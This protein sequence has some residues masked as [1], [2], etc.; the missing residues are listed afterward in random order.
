VIVDKKSN[1]KLCLGLTNDEFKCRCNEPSC[2]ATIISNDFIQAYESFRLV[3]NMPLTI[4][5][6]FRCH[7]K[8]LDVGGVALSQHQAGCAVDLVLTSLLE[9]YTMEEIREIAENCG[10]TFIKFYPSRSFFHMDVR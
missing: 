2:R 6:G 4:T 5:N 9:K 8:N 10:F 1:I 3:V 7:V